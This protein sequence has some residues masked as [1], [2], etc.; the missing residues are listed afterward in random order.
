MGGPAL[1]KGNGGGPNSAAGLGRRTSLAT[2]AAFGPPPCTVRADF[3]AAAQAPKSLKR[4]SSLETALV[5]A[6]KLDFAPCTYFA[7]L[8]ASM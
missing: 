2:V 7:F 1:G 5:V 4:S 6:S 8:S 3:R